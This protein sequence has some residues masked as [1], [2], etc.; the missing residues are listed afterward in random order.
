ME[1]LARFGVSLDG[2]PLK[3]FAAAGRPGKVFP[4]RELLRCHGLTMN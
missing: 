4:D 2:D 1:Q 3:R